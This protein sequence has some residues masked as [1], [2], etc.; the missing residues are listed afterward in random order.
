MQVNLYT[1][2]VNFNAKGRRGNSQRNAKK[3]FLRDL[4]AKLRDVCVSIRWLVLSAMSL[5]QALNQRHAEFGLQDV[6][7]NQQNRADATTGS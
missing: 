2:S 1:V 7:D 4:C 5:T 3:A 6:R